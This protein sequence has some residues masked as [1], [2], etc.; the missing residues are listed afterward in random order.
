MLQKEYYYVG[1]LI[2]GPLFGGVF[3]GLTAGI[4]RLTIGVETS[5]QARAALLLVSLFVLLCSLYVGVY[6]IRNGVL[7]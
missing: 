3:L 2:W 4:L 5:R 6:Y 1:Y 7:L